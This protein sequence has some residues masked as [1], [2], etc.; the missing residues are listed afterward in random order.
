M[1][2]ASLKSRF[3][4][5]KYDCSLLSE[6][7]KF[8]VLVNGCS[9][10]SVGWLWICARASGDFILD[11]WIC[12]MSLLTSSWSRLPN[13]FC[14]DLRN[15]KI[16]WPKRKKTIRTFSCTRRYVHEWKSIKTLCIEIYYCFFFFFF[17]H[18]NGNL[19]RHKFMKE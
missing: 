2:S 10:L 12:L 19:S 5:C 8:E 16:R 11:S 7:L 3:R 15:W 1:S 4:L 9:F 18:V 14:H 17:F 6:V 13:R